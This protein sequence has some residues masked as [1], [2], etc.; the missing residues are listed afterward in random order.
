MEEC[1]NTDQLGDVGLFNLSKLFDNLLAEPVSED[2]SMD[3]LRRVIE[4]NDRVGFELMAPF[5]NPLWNQ[6]S[7][8]DDSTLVDNRLAVPGQRRPAVTKRIHRG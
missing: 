8:L 7:V 4:R 3:R 1:K 2:V 6:L 5:T